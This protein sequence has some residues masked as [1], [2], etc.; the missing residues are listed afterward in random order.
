MTPKTLLVS[1]IKDGTVIDHI[2]AG[3]SLKIIELL[4]LPSEQATVTVGMHLPSKRLK[5]KDL[6]K[7]E[8]RELTQQEANEI[9][10]LSP[11]CT[12]NIIKNYTVTKKFP[13]SIP[14]RIERVIVCPNPRCI[15]NHESMNTVFLVQGTKKGIIL[16]CYYCEKMFDE[17]EIQE[18]RT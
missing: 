15:T 18:Y 16:A 6:I 14:D 10:I 8:N 9:A 5:H 3:R 1:A 11:E 4:R 12:I 2:T 17:K 7:I 13:I